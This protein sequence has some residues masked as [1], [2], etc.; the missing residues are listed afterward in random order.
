MTTPARYP[1]VHVTSQPPGPSSAGAAAADRGTRGSNSTPR[2]R[3]HRDRGTEK[4][5][6]RRRPGPAPVSRRTVEGRPAAYVE[7]DGVSRYAEL[8]TERM[9]W[10]SH[11][12]QLDGGSAAARKRRSAARRET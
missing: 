1:P 3:H 5:V 7:A 2:A 9:Y 4:S 11:I 6:P 8:P 12:A 10:R